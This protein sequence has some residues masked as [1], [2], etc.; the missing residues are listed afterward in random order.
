MAYWLLKT[1]PETYSFDDLL[2]EKTTAWDG[3]RNHQARNNLQAMKKG[4]RCLIYHSQEVRAVAGTA[5]VTRAA[6]PEPKGGAEGWVC[7]DLKPEARLA[8]PVTLA[9]IKAD[10]LLS[11]MALVRQGRLSVSPVG[12]AEWER[13]MELAK[14]E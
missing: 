10:R 11:K 9:E 1:D 6:Y 14:R 5:K 2:R 7:V 13:L 4:D 12:D 8:R 3:V